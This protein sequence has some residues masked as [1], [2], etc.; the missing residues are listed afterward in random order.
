VS[1]RTGQNV[2]HHQ[3]MTGSKIAYQ[4]KGDMLCLAGPSLRMFDAVAGWLVKRIRARHV[5]VGAGSKGFDACSAQCT[6]FIGSMEGGMLPLFI[7]SQCQLRL[8]A[9]WK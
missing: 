8:G 5:Q 7:N 4:I 9:A 2:D 3:V 1:Y 6:C